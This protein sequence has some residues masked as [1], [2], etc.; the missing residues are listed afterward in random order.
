[1]V[2]LCLYVFS[3]KVSRDFWGLMLIVS[4]LN[5]PTATLLPHLLALLLLLSVVTKMT[6]RWIRECPKMMI[7]M[8]STV[9]MRMRIAEVCIVH[10]TLIVVLV[11]S[12]A[13]LVGCISDP[14]ACIH[15]LVPQRVEVLGANHCL[16]VRRR[17]H[18]LGSP[19]MV[20]RL[21]Q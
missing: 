17:A 21:R 5:G 9:H 6:R 3:V 10:N 15:I 7:P 19:P 11:R 20:E 1:M 14:S 12:R 18:L 4:S 13:L 8:D 2:T 16:E